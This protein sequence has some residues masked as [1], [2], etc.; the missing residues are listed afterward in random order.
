MGGGL[1]KW[2]V[3]N[4]M[5]AGD[6]VKAVEREAARTSDIGQLAARLAGGHDPTMGAPFASWDGNR[7]TGSAMG[8]GEPPQPFPLGGEPR[9][10]QYRVGINYPS[11]PGSDRGVDGELLRVLADSFDLVRLCIEIRKN[12]MTHLEWDVV[13]KEKNRAKR[14]EW[15]K[16]NHAELEQ[17]KS[18]FE[19]PEAYT[20]QDAGGNW[21]RRGKVK[22][23][24]WL[25]ALLEDYFVGDWL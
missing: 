22:W 25:G 10:W 24:D 8:P 14:D 20:V 5:S 13:P 21:V 1:L 16:Q 2:A 19:W 7:M 9:Q 15:L 4:K 12:D 23:E 18:F 3:E 11:P 6:L 17:V